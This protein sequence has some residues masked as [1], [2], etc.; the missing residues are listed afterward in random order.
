MNSEACNFI[1][2]CFNCRLWQC[3]LVRNFA[4]S[5]NVS[6]SFCLDELKYEIFSDNCDISMHFN[7]VECLG[8]V[9]LVVLPEAT[10]ENWKLLHCC[11]VDRKRMGRCYRI[12]NLLK[13]RFV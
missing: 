5:G 11:Y 7:S 4:T 10:D 6:G 9:Y 2:N 12:M 3:R 1:I 8:L 13:Q